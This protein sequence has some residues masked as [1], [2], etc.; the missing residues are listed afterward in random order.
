MHHFQAKPPFI[1]WPTLIKKPHYSLGLSGSHLHVFVLLQPDAQLLQKFS[2]FD[3]LSSMLQKLFY[4]LF[5]VPSFLL[6]TLSAV[7]ISLLRKM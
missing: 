5:P 1:T 7:Y 2:V 3:V 6:S 4:N